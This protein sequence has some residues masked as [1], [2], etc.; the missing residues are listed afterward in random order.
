MTPPPVTPAP[1]VETVDRLDSLGFD[2]RTWV[3]VDHLVASFRTRA[4]ALAGAARLERDPC[5]AAVL[6]AR[7]RELETRADA[8]LLALLDDPA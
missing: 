8:L 3:D 4:D 6:R 2:G 5:G 7:G 1:A